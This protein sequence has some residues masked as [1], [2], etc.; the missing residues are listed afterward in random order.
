MFF[1][2]NSNDSQKALLIGSLVLALSSS[3]ALLEQPAHAI[4]PS[5]IEAPPE[6]LIENEE[7]H[8]ALI[9]T[10]KESTINPPQKLQPK[11]QIDEIKEKIEEEKIEIEQ[12]AKVEKIKK[13]EKAEE[14]KDIEKIKETR[15]I[16]ETKKIQKPEVLP[17]SSHPEPLIQAVSPQ[18]NQPLEKTRLENNPKTTTSKLPVNPTQKVTP[19]DSDSDPLSPVETTEVPTQKENSLASDDS[20]SHSPSDETI[21][22]LSSSL[23]TAKENTSQDVLAS[24]NP[25]LRQEL[26]ALTQGLHREHR[27]IYNELRDDEELAL[28]DI[29]MLWQAAI[30]RS[31]SI[32]FA[33]E[34][35]SRRSATGQP[36]NQVSFTKR[37]FQNVTQLTGTAAS[38][39]TG[40]PAGVLGGGLVQDLMSGDP[41][42]SAMSRVTD[43]DM[44]ILAKEVEKLQSNLIESYYH[45]RHAEA[46]WR[47]AQ[48]SKQ[49]LGKYYA[50][51]YTSFE[52][53]DNDDPSLMT[54]PQ[55]MSTAL[56][57]VLDALYNS[58]L[59]EEE[60]THRHYIS[61]RNHLGL[62][63]GGEALVALES[64]RNRSAQK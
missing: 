61:T 57:P 31:G 42:A 40:T 37:L 64:T 33:I 34:K 7:D 51:Q 2:L 10:T 29:T 18:Q 46:Q 8:E 32:R 55:I 63:V 27:A 6:L 60:N 44:L 9:S 26:E 43:A 23:E 28:N 39:W 14:I 22:E 25:Q 62:L 49:N 20:K 54:E 15:G 41:T 56:Q 3:Q 12:A 58:I 48:E 16:E 50:E 35:L 38:L 13:I 45:Y 21:Q 36:L 19:I 5:I 11:L 17:P 24:L 4:L 53:D 52:T 47:L 59:L 1:R 30:E